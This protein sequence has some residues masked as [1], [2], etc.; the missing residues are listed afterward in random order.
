MKTMSNIF[1]SFFDKFNDLR[2]HVAFNNFLFTSWFL[3][4]CGVSAKISI[5]CATITFFFILF[6][7]LFN[8][9]SD[10]DYDI[11]VDTYY[12][13]FNK[14]TYFILS[15]L[16]LNVGIFLIFFFK[17]TL[18]VSYFPVFV[19]L[20]LM[21]FFAVTYSV[22]TFF[23]YP[24]KNYLV[25]KTLYNVSSKFF[26]VFLL[27]LLFSP[28]SIQQLLIISIAGFC[29]NLI[30]STLW[31][32][33]DMR[34]DLIG[35]VRTVPLVIGK[36]KTLLLCGLIWL[37]SLILINFLG[38]TSSTFYIRYFILLFFII[39]II[40]IE[41]PRWFHIIIYAFIS[42]NL[43]F[44]NHELNILNMK[45]LQQDQNATICTQN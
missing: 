25:V 45:I 39:S 37:F 28:V 15:I 13:K 30:V 20:F 7:Y 40:K 42:L 41:R 22:K 43:L 36:K 18:R 29:I 34:S 14:N 5:I 21:I 32:I 27:A 17:E 16:S 6:T 26:L 11:F 3:Y 1:L 8:R 9:F 35:K 23:K 33:R 31:D 44:S 19:I 38:L 4:L 10:Y 12:K 24:L 2:I